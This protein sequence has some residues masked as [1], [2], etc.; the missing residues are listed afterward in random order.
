MLARKPLRFNGLRLS[1]PCT[2]AARL[3]SLTERLKQYE[4]VSAPPKTSAATSFQLPI[5]I[6]HLPWTHKFVADYAY[7][8]ARVES[9]FVDDPAR[10]GAWRDA[11]Q[12]IHGHT[13][14][15]GALAD[16][17]AGQQAARAAPPAARASVQRLRDDRAVAIV[18]GQQAGLFGGPLFTLLKAMTAVKLAARVGD[19][20][21]VPAVPVFWIDAEDHD[22]DEVRSC[23][24]LDADQRFHSVALP[25]AIGRPG[26]P[27]ASIVLDASIEAAL[28]ELETTLEA[29]EFTPSLLAQLRAAYRPGVSMSTAFG[30]WLETILGPHG[31]V[32]FDSADPAAKPLVADLF[33]QEIRA[34]GR[35]ANLAAAAGERLTAHGYVPQL[36]PQPDTVA[37][38]HLDGARRPLRGTGDTLRVAQTPR[39]ATDLAAEAA[40]HPERFSPNVILR[41]L[42]QD[43]LFPTIAYVAGPSELGYLGQL[44]DVYEAFGVPMPL[45]YPR[46]TATII[47]AAAARFLGRYDLPVEA[48]QPRDESAL[49]RLLEAQ[50]PPSVEGSL[51]GA[52]RAI[53]SALE[54]IIETVPAIDPTLE[55]ASRSTLGRMQNDL[56]K[57]HNKVIQA[58]KRKNETLRRQFTRTQGQVFPDGHLQERTLGLVYFLNRYGPALV[59]RLAEELPLDLG[60]HW[61]LTL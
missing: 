35:A 44:K 59:D 33:T 39:S 40:D 49:N 23:G 42:V 7:E 61:L 8:F 31:L 12:R 6:R 32:V 10:P 34:A 37:L 45:M 46:A 3:D 11:F 54:A 30:C 20:L 13:R 18:T 38:F 27:V 24:I 47:D 51:E 60:R 53:R 25:D 14:A 1:L 52:E 28:E 2:R 17:V 19:D 43:A 16:L 29:N 5:D 50:L 48:L 58:S 15:R 56:Q 57:L 36:T 41:P 21:D 26:S 4:I 22:W 9:F 55:G